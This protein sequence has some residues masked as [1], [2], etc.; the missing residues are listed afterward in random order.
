VTTRGID[1]LG[2]P[3]GARLHLGEAVIEV[4]GLRTPC[5]RL[6]GIRK[7]LMAATRTKV[8]KKVC[9]KAGVMAIVVEGGVVKPGD[10]IQV[11][12][13]AEPHR[14]LQPV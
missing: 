8:G 6:D 1:L 3:A 12:L 7:G 13:P 2:P 5:H 11:E 14:P 9:F 10:A 4:T